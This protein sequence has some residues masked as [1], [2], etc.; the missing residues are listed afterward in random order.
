[1]FSRLVIAAASRFSARGL[2][3]CLTPPPRPIAREGRAWGP[4]HSR[5]DALTFEALEQLVLHIDDN[6]T[7]TSTIGPLR[8]TLGPDNA[9]PTFG[10]LGPIWQ[11]TLRAQ[12]LE[13]ELG[14]AGIV[15][16]SFE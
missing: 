12:Q 16:P 2:S 8:L 10:R 3:S 6:G 4:P 11:A 7:P 13:D 1:M 14:L 15:E 5:S 9:S